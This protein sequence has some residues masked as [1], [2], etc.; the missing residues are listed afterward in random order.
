MLQIPFGGREMD[1]E[2]VLSIV[3]YYESKLKAD[4]IPIQRADT[5]II[6]RDLSIEDRLMHSHHLCVNVRNFIEDT[7]ISDKTHRH[8]ASLQMFLGFAGWYCLDDLMGHN[9]PNR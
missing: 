9:R 8:F 1:N 6:L 4:D 3:D 2:K 5:R 7:T